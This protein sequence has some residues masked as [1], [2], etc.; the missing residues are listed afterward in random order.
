MEDRLNEIEAALSTVRRT[1]DALT[2][3]G[4][5]E[6]AFDLARAQYAASV[7]TSWPANLMSLV[8]PM[9]RIEADEKLGLAEDERAALRAA[10]Q[11]LQRACDQ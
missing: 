2:A 9:A 4:N 5:D 11:A 1:L 10:I 3:R 6:A 8:G 7:R